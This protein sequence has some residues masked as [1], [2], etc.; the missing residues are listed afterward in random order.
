M[1]ALKAELRFGPVPSRDHPAFL[2][3]SS[4]PVWA[5]LR[6]VLTDAAADAAGAVAFIWRDPSGGTVSVTPQRVSTGVYTAA[7]TVTAAGEWV[8]RVELDG[9]LLAERG[10]TVRGGAF[11]VAA[12]ISGLVMLAR[13]LS[14]IM[15]RDGRVIALR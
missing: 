15:T 12:S 1:P 13:D 8:V 9:A 2:R 14:L 4:V 7:R 10:F 5:D 3:G 6:D 11:A